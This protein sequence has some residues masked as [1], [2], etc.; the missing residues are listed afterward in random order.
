M[1][2]PPFVS[3]AMN[4]NATFADPEQLSM[5]LETRFRLIGETRMRDLPIYRPDLAVETIGFRAFGPWWAG[6]LI[7]PWFMN[8]VL[9]PRLPEAPALPP[10]G[11]EL[12][13]DL[14][15]RSER[16][17]S[18]RDEELGAYL[19]LS[20]ASPMS[21]FPD[22]EAARASARTAVAA[23]LETHAGAPGQAAAQS[24]D[25]RPATNR[26]GFLRKLLGG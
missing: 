26:R 15:G 8:L 20:L 21:G 10:E 1:T 18:S 7:T 25:P 13:V 12:Q 14:A 9:F 5:E 23:L 19:A 17:I 22:Q 24:A 2:A 6:V 11:G 4:Q 16:F 3:V